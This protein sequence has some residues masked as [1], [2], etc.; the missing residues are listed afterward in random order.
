MGALDPIPLIKGYAQIGFEHWKHNCSATDKLQ[1]QTCLKNNI[2]ENKSQIDLHPMRPLPEEFIPMPDH[3][4][5]NIRTCFFRLLEISEGDRTQLSFNLF[6]VMNGDKNMGLRF[7]PADSAA[8]PHD[9]AHVQFCRRF[10]GGVKPTGIPTWLPQS[11]PAFPLP[12]SESLQ[13]F[14]AMLTSVHGRGSS[15]TRGV[16]KIIIEIFQK[17]GLANKASDYIDVLNKML[18]PRSS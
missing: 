14:L 13:L 15:N 8:S 7:E 3:G 5:R 9:Y 12:S 1:A 4:H 6:M 17:A 2:I 11:Y 18:D 16:R 10:R